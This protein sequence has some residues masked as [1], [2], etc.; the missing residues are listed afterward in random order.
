MTHL[1]DWIRRNQ[2]IAFFAILFVVT[3][4]LKTLFAW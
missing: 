3:W 2:I 4:R 1:V